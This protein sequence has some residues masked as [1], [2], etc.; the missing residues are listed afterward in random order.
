MV[1]KRMAEQMIAKYS[2]FQAFVR[3]RLLLLFFFFF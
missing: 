1:L 3:I 2:F